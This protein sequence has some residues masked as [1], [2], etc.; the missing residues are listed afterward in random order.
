MR[1][2]PTAPIA[3]VLAFTVSGA[4]A[5]LCSAQPAPELGQS[6][7]WSTPSDRILQAV[8]ATPTP[9]LVLD[10]GVAFPSLQAR[11]A[12]DPAAAQPQS[13]SNN[14]ALKWLG[15]GMMVAGGLWAL[16]AAQCGAVAAG[17]DVDG[18]G[19]VC[20][21]TLILGAGVGGAG[22]FVFDRNR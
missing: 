7:L 6:P 4:V 16:S 15:V 19:G 13:A 20:T 18:I 11:M 14:N 8:R 5:G 17:A 2:I 22:W 9:T 21:G 3:I 12:Q 10:R 1:T